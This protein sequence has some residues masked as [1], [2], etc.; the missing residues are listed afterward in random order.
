MV[1][2]LSSC[3]VY[4]RPQSAK[5]AQKMAVLQTAPLLWSPC[6]QHLDMSASWVKSV[7]GTVDGFGG[8]CVCRPLPPSER[9]S[10]RQATLGSIPST[11][12]S[13]GFQFFQDAF[14]TDFFFSQSPSRPSFF[15]HRRLLWSLF[16]AKRFCFFPQLLKTQASPTCAPRNSGSSQSYDSYQGGNCQSYDSYQG[17]NCQSYDSYQGSWS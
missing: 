9:S 17:G 12:K 3:L 6:T 4:Y 15:G 1:G 5:V 2:H 8:N 10:S 14:K 13:D 7:V 11:S 16:T